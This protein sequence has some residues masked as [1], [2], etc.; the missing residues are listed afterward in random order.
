MDYREPDLILKKKDL[1]SIM[2]VVSGRGTKEPQ[3]ADRYTA[4]EYEEKWTSAFKS[5][6]HWKRYTRKARETGAKLIERREKG[7]LFSCN[8]SLALLHVFLFFEKWNNRKNRIPLDTRLGPTVKF[9]F[10]INYHHYKE[11]RRTLL[12]MNKVKLVTESDLQQAVFP[13]RVKINNSYC[14]RYYKSNDDDHHQNLN[15]TGKGDM[16]IDHRRWCDNNGRQ[17]WTINS[18]LFFYS[19]T[20]PI[21]DLCVLIDTLLLLFTRNTSMT[22]TGRKEERG[23]SFQFP[24]RML[25]ILSNSSLYWRQRQEWISAGKVKKSFLSVDSSAPNIEH[26]YFSLL[27]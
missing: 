11:L 8:S 3:Y 25:F 1:K 23:K 21:I 24:R 10:K 5:S 14:S 12:N 18:S 20:P 9:T 17:N 13:F 19:F 6:T 16:I 22:R 27:Q 15:H 7:T 4:E 26:V 2:T